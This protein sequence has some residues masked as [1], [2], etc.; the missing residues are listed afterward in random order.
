LPESDGG[1]ADETKA[2]A[3]AEG[4]GNI[5]ALVEMDH[6]MG[7][8]EKIVGSS[9]TALDEVRFIRVPVT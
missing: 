5:Q 2:G 1:R 6:R 9:T 8:L 4:K 3:D 7:Q